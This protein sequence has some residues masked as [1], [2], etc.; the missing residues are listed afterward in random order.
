MK[1]RLTFI[2]VLSVLLFSVT[3]QNKI[4]VACIGNSVTYGAGIAEREKMSYPAQ[5]QKMLGKDYIVKNFGVNGA[6]LLKKGHNPYWQ[7]AAFQ[8]AQN[9][10]PDLVIIHLGLND[11]DPRNWPRFRDE[12]NADYKELIDTFEKRGAKLWICRLT[13]I[14]PTHPRFKSGTRDWFWQIQQEI[15]RVAS[16]SNVGLIDLHTPLYRRPDLFPDALHPTA[17]GATIIA[18]TVYSAI[19]KDYGGLQVPPIFSDHMVLQRN[20]PVDFWGITNAESKV[21]IQFNNKTQSSIAQPDGSWEITFPP[22][23]EGGPYNIAIDDCTTYKTISDVMIGEVW[24]CSG[25]SNMAF[26]L[27]HSFDAEEAMENAYNNQIRFFD[28][29]E[30]APTNNVA[31]DEETLQKTNELAYYKPTSWTQST[32][33]TASDFS[34]VGYYFGAML[35][36]ELGV[37]IGLINNAIG[38][39]PTESW[40]DR[41]SL[42]HNP[43]LV[44][45][46]TN[47][48]NSDFIDGWVRERAALNTEDADN[49]NQRHPYQPAYLFE[50]AIAPLTRFKIAGAIWYQGESNAHNIELHEK[51]FPA[52]VESWRKAWGYQ[53]PF[54]YAQLSSMEVGRETWGHF[55]DS[56]RRFLTAIPHSGMAVTSDVGNRTDV[57]PTQKMEVGERLALWALADNYH[58]DIVKSGPLLSNLKV[59]NEKMI[60]SFD[61]TKALKTSDGGSVREIEIAGEDKIYLP[62]QSFIRG[63]KLEVWNDTISAPVLVRYG[64]NSFSEGNLVN[65]ENLPA[66]TFSNEFE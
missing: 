58:Q 45:L 53:F 59:A 27:K 3:A 33:E 14:F 12:F 43:E 5:L 37:P 40:I 24:L 1:L 42:E 25:Q 15:K 22:M 46:L 21:T 19:T 64:W 51:L 44:D 4:E 41:Y 38:G 23:A 9:F 35:Q 52:L 16:T 54:Y 29:K 20:K 61:H 30:I 7:Q 62:A 17:E 31:W 18:K 63:N 49:L 55:R 48:K 65:E 13:P 6:T 10:S 34:A 50:S 32:R 8:E 36:K 26:Q 57:H 66:S 56:Q 39:S 47:W 60:L 28:M 11:T 2:F